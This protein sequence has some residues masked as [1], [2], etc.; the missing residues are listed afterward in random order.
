MS[1]EECKSDYPSSA[2]WNY[3]GPERG[4]LRDLISHPPASYSG[5]YQRKRKLYRPSFEWILFNNDFQYWHESKTSQFLW[6]RGD[7]GKGKTM[8][9]CGIIDELQQELGNGMGLGW[10]P[11]YFFCQATDNQFNNAESVLRGLLGSLFDEHKK[12]RDKMNR[13]DIS[14]KLDINDLDTLC[15]TFKQ[16]LQDPDL[17]GVYLIVDALDECQHGLQNLLQIIMDLSNLSSTK[18][19][20]LVSSRNW[21]SIK[22]ELNLLGQKILLQLELNKSSISGAVNRYICYKV[23]ELKIKKEYDEAQREDVQQHLESNAEDTFLWVA[24]VCEVL[25]GMDV[26]ARN[27]RKKLEAKFPAGLENFYGRMV[28]DI[29]NS[30]EDAP[31]Y[32]QIL[33]IACVVYRPIG[34]NELASLLGKPGLKDARS[35][36]GSCGSLLTLQE[37]GTEEE[38][39]VIS[40]VHQSAKDFLL[41]NLHASRQIFPDG[42]PREHYCVFSTSVELLLT[43]LKRDMYGLKDP[44]YLRNRASPPKPDPLAPVRYSCVYWADHLLELAP[45]DLKTLPAPEEKLKGEPCAD[46]HANSPYWYIELIQTM[47]KSLLTLYFLLHHLLWSLRAE[48]FH[49]CMKDE[50]LVHRFFKEKYLYWLEALSLLSSIPEGVKTMEKLKDLSVSPTHSR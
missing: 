2:D 34:W 14:Y 6:I 50:G 37:E 22:R 45:C 18:I 11:I 19:K 29:N 36:I 7:P 49:N 12:L 16:A 28:E 21:P 47:F 46:M 17:P 15:E 23:N 24:L 27:T 8:L 1:P 43:T 25:S 38:E 48:E 13:T 26:D 3:L 42:V 5:F 32:K 44:G 39:K 10:K 33:A 20:I 35:I 41:D 9:L 31:L 30:R 40:F 4:F